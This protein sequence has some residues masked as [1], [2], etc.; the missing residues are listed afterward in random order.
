MMRKPAKRVAQFVGIAAALFDTMLALHPAGAADETIY[1]AS[2]HKDS[3]LLGDTKSYSNDENARVWGD[4]TDG[5]GIVG[6]VDVRNLDGSH[7]RWKNVYNTGGKGTSVFDD[8]GEGRGMR[9]RTCSWQNSA[10]V[11]CGPRGYGT[12]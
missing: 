10:P 9:I 11:Y 8:S 5:Y 4:A 12:A 7:S 3:R 6:H 2:N 1:W